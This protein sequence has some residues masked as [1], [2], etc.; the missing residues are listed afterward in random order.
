MRI[1]TAIGL[2]VLGVTNAA[3]S[4]E[5]RPQGPARD[6]SAS[7]PYTVGGQSYDL[8]AGKRL[9]WLSPPPYSDYALLQ[10]GP[11][12]NEL[13]NGVKRGD[14]RCALYEDRER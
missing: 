9:C 3:H 7:C 14:P 6:S 13:A 5:P 1:L 12:L 4:E 10:C 11:P 8:P 2:L